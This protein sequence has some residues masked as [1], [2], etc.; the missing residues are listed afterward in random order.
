MVQL[1][2]VFDLTSERRCFDL[3]KLISLLLVLALVLS[4]GAALADLNSATQTDPK[5]N[6]GIKIKP[7][8]DN[9]WPEDGTS[10]TTG[11]N[12]DEVADE[13]YEDGFGGMSI[14]GKYYP[15]MVQHCGFAG[16]VDIG[17]P[18][19]G[20]CADIYYEIVKSQTGHTRMCMIFNDV[21]PTYA[22]GTRSTRV[23][24]IWIRQ[25]WNAPYFFLGRQTTNWGPTD[26][27]RA[28]ENLNIV[29]SA[30]N[31]IPWEEKYIF[32]GYAGSKQWLR[33][34]YRLEGLPAACNVLW[35]IA[36]ATTELLGER[37]F[38]DH[39]HTFKFGDL[40]EGGDDAENVYVI[41]NT[42]GAK[43]YD[44]TSGYWYYFNSMYQYDEDE[45]VYYRYM[46]EDMENPDNGAIAF[47]EQRIT[48]AVASLP[49]GYYDPI[50]AGYLLSATRVPGEEITF[51]N[52]IVQ[53]I[54]MDW[55]YGGECPLPTLKGTGNADF[56][57]GGKHYTG[58]WQRETYDDRTVFYGQ[59]GEE[60][61]LQ[62]GR[63]MIVLMDYKTN[64][65]R[66]VKYE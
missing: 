66:A 53:Y 63:T 6:R 47:C 49:E 55:S 14:T 17:A 8:G 7:A 61:A 30:A 32:D 24:Y 12:L 38:E 56:F 51:A 60:I 19:Y 42:Q 35:N 11:R 29:D 31:S 15:I 54:D 43:Q 46:I 21:L 3:K 22:G 65:L 5:A 28:L 18:F 4:C 41:F 48:D 44:G 45:N 59:N 40:P 34:K 9:P 2:T 37:S 58:V 39:N 27:N 10:P 16:G 23:G 57:M 62:P 1:H 26:V 50:G 64:G 36:N 33:F 20:A 52:I 25:E 13:Y